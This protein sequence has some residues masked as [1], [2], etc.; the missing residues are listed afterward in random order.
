MGKN[1]YQL[2]A[3]ILGTK[4]PVWRRLIVPEDIRLSELH[5]VLQAA[6]GWWNCH[7]HEFESHGTRYGSDGDGDGWGDP[8]EDER[9][10]RLRTIAEPGSSFLYVYDFGDDW[11]HRIVVEK[12]FP[13]EAGPRYPA[14]TGGRHACP[15]ED[16]GGPWGY[17]EFL[18]A[19]ND[20][21]HVEHES[22]LEWAGGQFDP[23]AFDPAGFQQRLDLGRL[24][25]R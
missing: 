6:F 21:S 8:P 7:L 10:T 16:C 15:P 3:T 14:C 17:Q 12:A 5:Q 22:M 1:V 19:I 20:T 13:A 25:A 18:A 11:R 4:P 24:I 2:K 9:R 23:D